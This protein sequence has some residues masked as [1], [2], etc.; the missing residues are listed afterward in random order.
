MPQSVDADMERGH[1]RSPLSSPS[2]SFISHPAVMARAASISIRGEQAK[3][4]LNEILHSWITRKFGVG[5]AILFPVAVTCY[6]V[7]WF[8]TFF[9]NLFSPLWYGV[10][11]F[12][13]FGL[14]FLTSMAFILFVGES[15]PL[16][17]PPLPPHDQTL[18]FL[19]GSSSARGSAGSCST[20][21]SGSSTASHSSSRSTLHP[22]RSVSP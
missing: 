3:K 8:L 14:G 18:P 13:V 2:S 10:F 1:S 16:P 21:A 9:E 5:A 6:V 4:T 7:W 12:H 17:S 20:L 15:S 11:R 22:S 19:Q